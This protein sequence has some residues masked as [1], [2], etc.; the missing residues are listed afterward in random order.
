MCWTV[1]SIV[2]SHQENQG[3]NIASLK[4]EL[5]A[6]CQLYDATSVDCTL[7]ILYQHLVG[8][9]GIFCP[10]AA[11][12]T[13]KQLVNVARGKPDQWAAGYSVILQQM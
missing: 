13:L 11:L 5:A 9:S 1:F 12:A 8:L 7:V 4:R 2:L 6:L 10:H 3:D